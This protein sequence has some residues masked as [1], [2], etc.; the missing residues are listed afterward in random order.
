[1]RD[2]ALVSNAVQSLFP[3]PRA[4]ML[5]HDQSSYIPKGF[6]GAV[7]AL[8]SHG[9]VVHIQSHFPGPVPESLALRALALLMQ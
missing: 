7:T 3:D 9:V 6:K 2:T 8:P 4:L 5:L 1:M